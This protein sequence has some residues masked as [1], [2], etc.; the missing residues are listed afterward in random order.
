MNVVSYAGTHYK[1]SPLE[2]KETSCTTAE[3]V[4][5]SFYSQV[6][7]SSG[8]TVAEGLGCAYED[9][10]ATVQCQSYSGDG[11]E[12]PVGVRWRERGP[13]ASAPRVAGCRAFTI[14]RVHS[15]SFGDY[16]YRATSVRRS[17]A[18]RCGLARKLLKAAYG[19]GPL[20]VV[21]TVYPDVGRPTYWLRGGWR[22]GNGA[23]GASCWNARRRQLN[24]IPLE[25]VPHGFAVTADVN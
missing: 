24:V 16:K 13:I 23:G 5:R 22:C 2:A 8:A 4:V 20:Q 12:G 17:A 6:I 1:A 14:L 10:G 15:R 3:A 7:G 25:G 18:I 9:H 19:R 11:Y 21:R